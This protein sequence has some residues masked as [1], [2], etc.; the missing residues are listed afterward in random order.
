[1]KAF[2]RNLLILLALCLCVLISFQWIRETHLRREIQALTDTIHDKMESIQSLQAN[3]RRDEAEIV[4]LDGLKSQ[5]TETVKSNATQIA[6]LG[7][8]LTRASNEV[9]RAERQIESYKGAVETANES[10]KKQ[11]ESIKTLN[12][13]MLKLAQDRNE[14]VQ[15]LN[16]TASNYNA[17]ADQW[18]KQQE[19][20]AKAATNAPAARK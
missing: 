11:N 15:R 3:V 5:M 17:L 7:R 13:E 14:I 16:T 12:E 1:M 6:A 4:R 10:I 8:D 2:L 9:D 19:E 18:N 20:L